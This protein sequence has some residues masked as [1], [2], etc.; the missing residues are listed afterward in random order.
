MRP[1]ASLRTAVLAVALGSGS[2]ASAQPPA[3]PQPAASETGAADPDAAAR[4][5]PRDTDEAGFATKMRRWAR[6]KQLLGRLNG[7]VDGWYPRLGGI[8][9]GSGF[10]AG[11]GI[12]GSVLNGRVFVDL[13][14]A[15]SIKGYTAFDARARWLQT[16]G[17]R[18]EIWTEYRYEDFP[19]ED[20]FGTGMSSTPQMRTSYDFDSSD[21]QV[22]GLLR[23][24]PWARL[25]AAVGYMRPDVGAGTDDN[26]PS[27]ET[28]FTDVDAPGLLEQPHYLHTTVSTEI[29]Y[30]DTAGNTAEGGYYRVSF[31]LWNDVTL[32][33]FDFRRFDAHLVQFVPVVP[34]K[35]HVVSGRIG[36]SYVNND[37]G[38][39]VPFY[40]LP[41]VG[42]MDTIRSFREFRFEDENAMWV[43]AE[44]KW[45]PAA[46]LSA[47]VFAD[48]GEARA[49]WE[50]LD[51]RG[52]RTGYGFGVGF[53]SNGQT[54][55]RLDLGTGGGEGWQFFIKI[56]PS[57]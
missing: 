38:H 42:G 56:R 34:S 19:E 15:L 10:A 55:A 16:A 12:R 50:A 14:G 22:R 9:R 39:R 6:D 28:R 13:S 2:A 37:A 1:A 17:K 29:D 21:V 40:F 44:Y 47:G 11:P 24:R 26:Y 23:P 36:A 4:Q 7:E 53:H 32:D 54:V 20:F 49:D 8:T 51:L 27:I 33:R 18:F 30:R 57:F 35:A 43:S 3:S 46:F 5:E 25:V 52:M 41:Y 31:G 45:R 48:A